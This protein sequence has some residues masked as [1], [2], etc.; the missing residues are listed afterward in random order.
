MSN[1]KLPA[2]VLAKSTNPHNDGRYGRA[3]LRFTREWRVLKL[4]EESNPE[5][6][7]ITAEQYAILD[8]DPLIVLKPASEDDAKAYEAE[9]ATHGT[10]KD[11]LIDS[12]RV[13]NAEL[14]ARLM[15]LELAMAGKDKAGGKG[16]QAKG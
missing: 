7:A 4:A 10:N 2:F 8:K 9:L 3:G 16:D 15:K 6:G 14:E 12:L 11:A 5:T 13:K 1:S